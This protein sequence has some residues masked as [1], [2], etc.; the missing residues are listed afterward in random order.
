MKILVTGGAGF[1]GSNLV[2]ELTK[3]GHDV[4]VLDNFY[5]GTKK[6]LEGLNVEIVNGDIRDE[7]IVKK[8]ANG[9]D[10]IFN[11]A[12]ASSSPMFMENLRNA[13]SA[14][15]DGFVNILDAAKE[16]SAKV[17]Y[18]STSSIYANLSPP[19]RE[20]MNVTP[21]NFYSV[22]KLANE[23][24][25]HVYTSEYGIETVGFRYM[26]V[27]GPKEDG[28]GVFANLVSQFL[29]AMQRDEQPVI[30]GDGAQTRDFVYVK[31]VVAANILAM[32]R[33]RGSEVFNVGTGVATSLNSLIALLNRLL[34]K[35]INP[36]CIGMPVRN[37]INTQLADISKIKRILGFT[38]KYSLEDGIREMLE[39]TSSP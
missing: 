30:Y 38:P 4:V 21:P 11:Q 22:T 24:L 16:N 2:E 19:L 35:D 39:T 12:A 5:L 29:W 15:I 17:I 25:A 18:A 3:Q 10:C 13:V 26:S 36:K 1:I 8:S 32:E 34:E 27:Y 37:Y 7:K 31:D 33:G 20:D 9:I 28:K 14:N 6:N 23:H